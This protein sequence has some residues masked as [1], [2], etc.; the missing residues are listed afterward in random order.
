MLTC[1]IFVVLTIA[2]AVLSLRTQTAALDLS[3]QTH[4]SAVVPLDRLLAARERVNVLETKLQTIRELA[5][6]EA[7]GRLSDSE[8]GDLRQ[9][10]EF[11]RADID[12]AQ[13]VPLPQSTANA[14]GNLRYQLSRLAQTDGVV[15]QRFA[16]SEL[17][18]LSK[19]LE[20]AIATTQSSLHML[21][22]QAQEKA[23]TGF[24]MIGT[25]VAVSLAAFAAATLLLARS[26]LKALS[27]AE[28]VAA[29]IGSDEWSEPETQGAPSETRAM[30]QCFSAINAQVVSMA[31]T[32]S[33]RSNSLAGQLEAKQDHLSAAL[34]NM[35]Q[36]LCML[37]GKKNLVMA[38]EVFASYFG[39]QPI[40]TP[41]RKFL[42]D[43]RIYA[44]L[45]PNETA[46]M[47]TETE[48]GEVMAVRR[49][50]MSDRGLLVT[51]DDVTER[52]KIARELEHIAAHDGLTDLPNRYRFVEEV[53]RA[54]SKRADDVTL[55]VLD[56]R[57]FKSINDTYGHAI[58][59]GIL[60][61][62]GA[63]LRAE[64]GK[65]AFVARLGGD[66][67]GL[68]LPGPQDA[69]RLR[70][71]SDQLIGALSEPF[72]IEGRRIAVAPLFGLA[73]S[74]IARR[75]GK[76]DADFLLQNCDLAIDEAKRTG[77]SALIFTPVL[78]ERQRERREMEFDLRQAVRNGE[79]VLHYQ[80]LVDAGR[81]AVSGFEA[82]MRWEHPTRGFLSPS[83]FI[84]LAEEIGIIEE[85]GA[86][87]LQTA[88]REAASWSSDLSV[89]VNMS[90]IQ[91]GSATLLQDLDR[92][93]AESGLDPKRLQIEVTESVLM[94]EGDRTIGMLRAMRERGLTLSMDDF[95]TGYSS[96]G[97]ISRFP[98][99]KIKIDQSFVRDLRRPENIAIV[100]S[101]ISLSRALNMNV[102]A[103]GIETR[104]QMDILI[105]EGCTDMQGYFFAKP[106]PA[107][108]IAGVVAEIDARWSADLSMPS[109]RAGRAIARNGS[110]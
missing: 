101:I 64:T 17:A 107:T 60:V 40:G 93:L 38:N 75:D 55:F 9:A 35:T 43:P 102:L 14:M 4:D 12:I 70:T 110:K 71:I 59:D 105:N 18:S 44:P 41:A 49:H 16:R 54:L 27:D 106:R 86:W 34:D 66:E 3:V 30:L 48:R 8:A 53:D 92:A 80:P 15:S 13:M 63:R 39:H 25:L 91:F 65:K 87:T 100:R 94:H 98:F 52:Q 104:E 6:A 90:P 68:L 47:Q 99:D 57:N 10:I 96:L 69:M 74:S 50:G 29:N 72:D 5:P 103:E 85:M 97:Y 33:N 7:G 88:C 51:F 84:P 79:L 56:L 36:G 108:D 24:W 28:K 22:T 67:F 58:G 81:C 42:S 21:K 73:H 95:G 32:L 77:Q 89:S 46:A 37:D 45:A 2:V 109:A 61:A 62:V 20:D 19:E 83:V 26:I 78:R 1:C 76:E 82:L 31:A 11:I 23:Q